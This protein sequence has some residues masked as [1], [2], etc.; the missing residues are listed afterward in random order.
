MRQTNQR[1]SAAHER[2][3]ELEAQ[4]AELLAALR[5][6]LACIEKHVPPTTFAP[7]EMARAAIAKATA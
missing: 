2:I 4:N 3:R 7:R 1:G 6:A 5:G